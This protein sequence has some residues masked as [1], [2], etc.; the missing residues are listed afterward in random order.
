[1]NSKFVCP[2]CK[3]QV[4]KE[5]SAKPGCPCCGFG[6]PHSHEDGK[7]KTCNEDYPNCRGHMICG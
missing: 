6:K 7:C 3:A 4:Q 2:S 5:A 1:M